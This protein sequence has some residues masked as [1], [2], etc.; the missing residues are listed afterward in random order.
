M[1]LPCDSI[2]G[3]VPI[4]LTHHAKVLLVGGA[5]VPDVPTAEEEHLGG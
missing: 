4:H 1:L 3:P 5:A 2:S